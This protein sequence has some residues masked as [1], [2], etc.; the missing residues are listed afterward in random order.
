MSQWRR[1]A[2]EMAPLCKAEAEAAEIP[3]ALWVEL[4]FQFENAYDAEPPDEN[5]INQI[6]A[7]ARWCLHESRNGDIFTAV[8]YAFYEHVLTHDKVR[9]DLPNHMSRKDFLGLDGYLAYHLTEQEFEKYQTEF[10]AAKEKWSGK[11]GGR[12][13]SL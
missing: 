8:V 6:Y 12:D 10:L 13:W 1:K 7:Y 3:M 4:H 5:L 11:N 9:K 2:I